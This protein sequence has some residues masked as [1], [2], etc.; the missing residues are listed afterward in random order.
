[1]RLLIADDHDL[2]RDGLRLL[3]EKLDS[4]VTVLE[5]GDYPGALALAEQNQDLDLVVLDLN[6]PGMNGLAGVDSFRSK[7]PDVP[8]LVISGYYLRR[9]ALEALRRGAAGF[10]PKNMTS[11]AMLNAFRL[12]L[13]GEK[14]IPS[15]VLSDDRLNSNDAA[16]V[17]AEPALLPRPL[18]GRE[19]DVLAGLLEGHTNKQIG[20]GLGIEEITVKMHLSHIYQKLG[21]KNRAQAVRI[22][23]DS[24]WRH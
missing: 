3:L 9:D 2:V 13:S 4:D 12:V 11:K 10:M 14:F 17:G 15:D 16:A 1:M 24:G 5:S 7:F 6:M 19:Q 20:R 18:T 23:M 22:A 21:A 8:T